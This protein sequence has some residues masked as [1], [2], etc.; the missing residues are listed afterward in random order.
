MASILTFPGYA[1]LVSM[2]NGEIVLNFGQQRFRR[3]EIIPNTLLIATAG[4]R[5]PCTAGDYVEHYIARQFGIR[6]TD[7]PRLARE[8]LAESAPPTPPD[9][10]WGTPA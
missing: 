7:W 10:G 6:Q 8:F 3:D 9:Q 2:K 4:P 5:F 1:N